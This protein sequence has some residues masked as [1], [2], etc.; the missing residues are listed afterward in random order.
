MARHSVGPWYRQ[1]KNTWYATAN[2][3]SISLGVK[4]MG[5]ANAQAATAA[6]HRLMADAM[7]IEPELQPNNENKHIATDTP[8]PCGRK[9]VSAKA[10]AGKEGRKEVSP[11]IGVIIEAFLADAQARVSSGCHRN[12]RLF[13]TP[14]GKAFRHRPA[15]SLTPSEAEAFSRKAE[16][17][18]TYRSQCLGCVSTLMRWA[19]AERRLEANPLTGLKRPPKRS[20]GIEAVVSEAE[21]QRFLAVADPLMQDFLAMLWATGARP[22]EIAGLTAEA[23]A[24]AVDGVIVLSVH[25]EAHK[26]KSRMLILSGDALARAQARAKAIGSGLLFTGNARQKLSPQSLGSRMRAL[27]SKAQVRRCI[28]YG[29]RHSFATQALSNGIA[30]ATVAALLGHSG[31]A[32]LHKHYSHLLSQTSTLRQ[33]AALVR[34]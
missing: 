1:S 15:S 27:C 5:E 13:L 16:W 22:G 14:F 33:A 6:W 20:R 21:H 12:Y 34:A 32:M 9:E 4:G 28:A 11:S 24:S 30:D 29:Y 19:V 25:K 8:K 23:I 10:Q 18:S 26:G 2:G 17:S 7:A 31:T 3:K